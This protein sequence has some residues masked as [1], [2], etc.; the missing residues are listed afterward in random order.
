MIGWREIDTERANNQR[1]KGDSTQLLTHLALALDNHQTYVDQLKK[2]V[3]GTARRSAAIN[4]A[5]GGTGA[6]MIVLMIFV[7]SNEQ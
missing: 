1:L 6:G 7:R 5:S 4:E 2:Q 3:S